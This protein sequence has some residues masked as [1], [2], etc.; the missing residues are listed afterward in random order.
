MMHTPE[1]NPLTPQPRKHQPGEEQFRA[2]HP[3]DVIWKPFPAF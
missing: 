2:I 3:E 1:T